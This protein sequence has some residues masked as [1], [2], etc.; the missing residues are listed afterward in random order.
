ML[1]VAAAGHVAETESCGL[2][3]IG[4]PYQHEGEDTRP[5]EPFRS[6]ALAH[7]ARRTQRRLPRGRASGSGTARASVGP[8]ASD[9]RD[10]IPGLPRPPSDQ[11]LPYEVPVRPSIDPTWRR[12]DRAVTTM[13][14]ETRYSDQPL[15]TIS[16]EV[17]QAED[18]M[19]TRRAHGIAGMQHRITR[20]LCHRHD[21][22]DRRTP[23]DADETDAPSTS[24]HHQATRFSATG[25]QIMRYCRAAARMTSESDDCRE[26]SPPTLVITLSEDR[27]LCLP[28]APSPPAGN[29][30]DI[31]G[32]S[33]AYALAPPNAGPARRSAT[34]KHTHRRRISALLTLS[35]MLLSARGLRR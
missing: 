24:P 32:N 5:R 9:G 20:D 14:P 1:P 25:Q 16:L 18:H 26:R 23:S 30:S 4:P 29:C 6:R 22:H 21:A 10:A 19:A 8:G 7:R 3:G 15:R 33:A 2:R 13:P 31:R 35:P 17:N 28:R 12:F 11:Q 27:L 34:T